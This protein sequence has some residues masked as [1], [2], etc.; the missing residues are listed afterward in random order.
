MHP[1]AIER[2]RLRLPDSATTVVSF[3][4]FQIVIGLRKQAAQMR[5]LAWSF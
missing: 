3:S 5:W 2:A 1:E 4:Q